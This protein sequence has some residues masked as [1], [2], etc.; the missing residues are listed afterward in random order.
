MGSAHTSTVIHSGAVYVVVSYP[1][2]SSSNTKLEPEKREL[3]ANGN[4]DH[5]ET[6]IV[7]T[8]VPPALETVLVPQDPSA[9]AAAL[10]DG[11]TTLTVGPDG[12]YGSGAGPGNNPSGGAGSN[13]SNGSGTTPGSNPGNNPTGGAGAG[14]GSG[15]AGSG[16]NNG[17][18]SAPGNGTP[19]LPSGAYGQP[20]TT[21]GQQP[22]NPSNQQPSN[23]A[24]GQ[25]QSSAGN[26]TPN[27]TGV[28]SPNPSGQQSP[29]PNG[30]QPPNPTITGPG[31]LVTTV[32][33]TGT[34]LETITISLASAPGN[35]P[36]PIT[37]N[38]D[39]GSC[40][41]L[42]SPSTQSPPTTFIT[43]QGSNTPS[44]PC[45]SNGTPF[46][47]PNTP[48]SPTITI[49]IPVQGGS[50]SIPTTG[51]T[52]N[53]VI[54]TVPGGQG[55][56]TTSTSAPGF[57]TTL[58]PPGWDSTTSNIPNQVTTPT[59][60]GWVTTLSGSIWV[61]VPGTS[62]IVPW[63][64]QQTASSSQQTLSSTCSTDIYTNLVST[65]I[66]PPDPTDP[67][68]PTDPVT[69]TSAATMAVGSST[70]LQ[71]TT[72]SFVTTIPTPSPVPV[73]NVGVAGAKFKLST[74][75]EVIAI[76]FIVSII[77]TI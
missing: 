60:A 49:T 71:H 57:T 25:P 55:Q 14:P 44:M 64:S 33:L 1:S 53:T 18:G 8:T 74:V 45:E 13:P 66:D 75:C 48:V 5:V 21:A 56:P 17:P 15:G 38:P 40:G 39:T 65:S 29:N 20:P 9:Q 16:P 3:S 42:S 34:I 26:E 10:Q 47:V 30:Q 24:G 27:P 4:D 63:N 11:T 77:M 19:G 50:V 52:P 69:T 43:I 41:P 2:A 22:P 59:T 31:S 51:N 72:W 36:S 37:C 70:S 58:S 73:V 68:D 67:T 12:A 76:A 28:Q 6:T 62:V 46:P 54:V 32:P 7:I 61:T 35:S 23:S